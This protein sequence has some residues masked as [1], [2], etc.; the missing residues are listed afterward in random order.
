MKLVKLVKHP[1]FI[2]GFTCKSYYNWCV[3][4][5]NNVFAVNDYRYN[6]EF[7]YELVSHKEILDKYEVAHIPDKYSNFFIHKDLCEDITFKD[8][9]D[10]ILFGD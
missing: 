3:K 9:I 2:N 8:E 4:N 5:L 1:E 6:S 10:K 7:F